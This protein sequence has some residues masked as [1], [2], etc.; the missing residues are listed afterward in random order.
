MGL[1]PAYVGLEP[2]DL[3]AGLLERQRDEILH[4]ALVAG[5]RWDAD[6]ILRQ[7]DAGVGVQGLQRPCLCSFP[8]HG[9]SVMGSGGEVEGAVAVGIADAAQEDAVLAAFGPS[10]PTSSADQPCSAKAPATSR[11]KSR[12]DNARIAP[13]DRLESSSLHQPRRFICEAIATTATTY[14]AM[15]AKIGMT[16]ADHS[17]RKSDWPPPQIQRITT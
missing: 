10:W 8:D 6:E 12:Q 13:S 5:H 4:G 2:V 16:H 9:V 1:E 17:Q 14:A 7:L 11:S 15:N 3:E